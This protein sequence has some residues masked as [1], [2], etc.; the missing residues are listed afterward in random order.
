MSKQ[1]NQVMFKETEAAK[2]LGY[3]P[4]TM[5]RMRR[6]GEIQH[7]D[8]PAGVRYTAWQLADY[9]RVPVEKLLER[10]RRG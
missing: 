3:H 9:M 5:R 6:S 8:T 2:I 7:T 1:L 4:N 10:I